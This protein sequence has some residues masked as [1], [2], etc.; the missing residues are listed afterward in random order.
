LVGGLVAAQAAPTAV[1][2]AFLSTAALT[3]ILM[4]VSIFLQHGRGIGWAP[5]AAGVIAAVLVTAAGFVWE[6]AYRAD[7]DGELNTG[8]AS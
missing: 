7:L 2:L 8:A 3:L 4:L 5:L 1:S 6:A